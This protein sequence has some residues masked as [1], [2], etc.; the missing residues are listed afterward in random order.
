MCVRHRSN[1][2]SESEKRVFYLLKVHRVLTIFINV[3]WL[4]NLWLRVCVPQ[5]PPWWRSESNT[6]PRPVWRSTRCWRWAT[7]PRDTSARKQSPGPRGS[8]ELIRDTFTFP[9]RER[10]R[11]RH[12]YKPRP[13]AGTQ[14]T[15]RRPASNTASEKCKTDRLAWR[16]AVFIRYNT[17]ASVLVLVA[18]G[19]SLV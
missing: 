3:W 4:M 7:G 16:S 10:R 18:T 6:P 9:E 2:T 13:S 15:P 1:G 17:R 19:I 12:R 5:H 8:R 11:H 14:S